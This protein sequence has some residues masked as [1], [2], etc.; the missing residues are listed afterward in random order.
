MTMIDVD[1][2][3]IHVDGIAMVELG[4]MMETESSLVC[5]YYCKL[6]D[7]LFFELI[8]LGLIVDSFE[9]WTWTQM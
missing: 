3:L 6:F 1:C 7:E 2:E 9:V 4:M 5:L 8:Y